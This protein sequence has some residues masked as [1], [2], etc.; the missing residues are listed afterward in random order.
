MA[1]DRPGASKRRDSVSIEQTQHSVF[2]SYARED[3]DWASLA[4][5]LLN[6]GGAEVFADVRDAAHGDR[7][8]HALQSTL[9]PVERV[10]VFWSRH[11]AASGWVQQ[12][13]RIAIRSGKRVV[14]VPMDDTPLSSLL[15]QSRALTDLKGLLQEGAA[16]GPQR[17]AKT[18]SAFRYAAWAGSAGMAAFLALLL[19]AGPIDLPVMDSNAGIAGP[20]P[21]SVLQSPNAVWALIAGT[22]MLLAA[23]VWHVT[24]SA[25][26]KRTK[27]AIRERLHRFVSPEGTGAV[28]GTPVFREG[29]GRRVV[30]MVFD[31][32]EHHAT[33]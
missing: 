21:V 10:L 19:L 11:A 14:L 23:L 7:W 22:A 16:K 9:Q 12:E 1:K 25:R 27:R 8:Q 15:W 13:C 18:R 32:R 33:G 28:P 29:L 20:A 26:K 4:T 6:A 31:D 3:R 5:H 17:P 30:D 24:K 2:V